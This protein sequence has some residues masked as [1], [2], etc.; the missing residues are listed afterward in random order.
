MELLVSSLLTII[1]GILATCVAVLLVE[2]AAAFA[3]PKSER[4][5]N[6]EPA[7]RPS[8]AVLVPAHNESAGLLPTLAD[9]H[10]QSLSSDRLVVVADNC[11]DDTAGV[12]AAAGAE[13]V[14]RQDP[15]RHGKGYALD[16]GLR[17]LRPDPPAIVIVL[18]ADC[19][20]GPDAITQL[21]LKCAATG[22]PVQALYMMTAPTDSKM[23]QQVA[24]FAWR[25]KNRLRPLGLAALNLPCQLM[26]TGM[27]F[28][29]EVIGSAELANARLVEDLTLGLDLT[30]AGHPPIFCPSACVKSQFPSTPK[31][32]R[33]QRKRWEQG[34][35]GTIVNRG[36]GLLAAAIAR[37]NWKLLGLVFDMA[38][39][40][41]SL[42]GLLL[43]GL[44]AAS[45]IAAFF[46]YSSTALVISTAS[47]A[48][49][50]MAIG[51]AWLTCGYDVLPLGSIGL[52]PAY[53]IKKVRLYYQF[54]VGKMDSS[55][56]R[57]DRSKGG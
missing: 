43:V 41:L 39:P 9:I 32:A 48:A 29:W 21:S 54:I 51:L 46:G 18:D 23:N 52:V 3:L 6:S 35:I 47:L 19:T 11:Q 27:A 13:V 24:E 20:L 17:Y 26:G 14:E 15:A 7:T 55:W 44:L 50:L 37:R 38:V 40:P 31:A 12:A 57:T 33:S 28:P 53:V 22:R 8:V 42:L 36:P 1:A 5:S 34:H 56:I 49:F 10:S 45:G 30:L 4:P 25:V 2:I 16:C